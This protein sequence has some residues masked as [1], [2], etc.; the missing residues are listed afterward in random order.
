MEFSIKQKKGFPEK[1]GELAAMMEITRDLTLFEVAEFTEAEL[2]MID[3]KGS[4][5]IGALLM[6]IAAIEF[7]H[8]VITFENRDLNEEEQKK[9][10]AALE[11]GERGRKA[12]YGQPLDYYTDILAEVRKNTLQQ[13][14][15]QQDSWLYEEGEWDNG[16]KHNNYY[17]WFHV[18]EDEIS[19]RGQIRMMR[20]LFDHA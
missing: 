6:H 5:S 9:W 14:K 4:N 7:V 20:R 15:K 17:L 8:Q 1:I 12:Y 18:I 13:M 19:H 3:D 16:I 11:L 10:G 2:D